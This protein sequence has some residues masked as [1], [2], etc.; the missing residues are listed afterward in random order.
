[1]STKRNGKAKKQNVR[2]NPRTFMECLRILL[3]KKMYKMF[4]GI[5][6]TL[7]DILLMDLMDDD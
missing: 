6:I 7:N 2:E 3:V 1:M 4:K 5:E